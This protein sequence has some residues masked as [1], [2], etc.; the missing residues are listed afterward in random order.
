MGVDSVKEAL[1]SL[2]NAD[3]TEED[4][5]RYQRETALDKNDR[6]AAILL[7]TNLENA[8]RT[9]IIR[10]LKVSEE[11]RRGLFRHNGP[12]AT[13]S[14]KIV[15][16]YAVGIIGEDTRFN[17]D[18]IRAI[19]NTFAHA[20]IPV[21]FRTAQIMNACALLRLPLILSR[22]GFTQPVSKQINDSF[23]GKKRFKATCEIISNNLIRVTGPRGRVTLSDPLGGSFEMPEMPESLP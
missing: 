9:A 19:R 5:A 10:K 1:L 17:L 23:K 11:R 20:K 8:L 12:F 4:Y 7:A 6:S 16:A 18:L 2:S 21:K 22:A 13:F 3:M 15:V 14:N